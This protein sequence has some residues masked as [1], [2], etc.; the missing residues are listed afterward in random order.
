MSKTIKCKA[1]GIKAN[2]KSLDRNDLLMLVANDPPE[3][4]LPISVMR[5]RMRIVEA[6]EKA[7]KGDIKLEDADFNTLKSLF[8]A[9]GWLQPHKDLLELADHLE[10]VSKQKEEEVVLKKSK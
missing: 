6:I 9:F 10:E 8:D 1:T 4:G 5:D 7:N 3:R 2:G